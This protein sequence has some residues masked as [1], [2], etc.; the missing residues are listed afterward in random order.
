MTG[1]RASDLF[2]QH[3]FAARD[4]VALMI[5]VCRGR[6]EL[7][8]RINRRSREMIDRGLVD[9]TRALR[10]EFGDAPV[11]RTIGYSQACDLLD[12]KIAP[13]KL[14]EEIAL[15]TRR[16]AKRQMTFLRNEP[17]KRGWV[18]RPSPSED[19][20]ELVGFA[21]ESKRARAETKGFRVFEMRECELCDRVAD[22]LR[23]PLERTEVWYVSLLEEKV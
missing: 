3:M 20:H 5:V 17:E 9:E 10:A 8:D 22:R 16:F 4:V 14:A 11:L 21:T 12:G 15:Y 13:E 1:K 23:A 18:V 6:D 2:D 19:A 7:Y